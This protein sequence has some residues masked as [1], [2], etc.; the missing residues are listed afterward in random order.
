M[1]VGFLLAVVIGWANSGIQATELS[2]IRERG[3][4]IVGVKDNLRPLGFKD[5]Q[6]QLQGFE[7]D[8]AQ[9]LA[10]ELL[11]DETAVEFRPLLNQDRL[12]ALLSGEVDLVVARLTITD[13]RARLVDFSRPY[14]VDGTGF[15]TRDPAIQSL[16]DLQQQTVA[17]LAGADTIP[18][19]RSLLPTV[20]LQGVASYAEAKA[21][22][23]A[24]QVAAF[25]ADAALLTGWTQEDPSYHLIPTLISAE[26]LAIAMPKGVQHD[27]LRRQ[28]NQAVGRWQTNGWLRRRIAEWDLP[29]D[30]FPNFTDSWIDT[31]PAEPAP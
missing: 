19:V 14:Y 9:Q 3:Y 24:G 17:V 26:A 23:E 30:G 8:I 29:A 1:Q 21:L 7:I 16:R 20:R 18:T 5:S 13:A 22:L 12:N 28:V 31:V 25:A 2:E 4:L 10:T 11:G 6:N 15:L 27:E